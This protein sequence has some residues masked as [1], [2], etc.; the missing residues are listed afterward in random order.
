MCHLCACQQACSL[1]VITAVIREYS[2][3]CKAH[4]SVTLSLMLLSPCHAE[5]LAPTAISAAN[6]SLGGGPYC[7]RCAEP[8]SGLP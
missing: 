3:Q 1:Q 2:I 6:A 4:R 5:L 7:C 8:A